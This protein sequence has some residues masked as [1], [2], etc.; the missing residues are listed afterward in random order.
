VFLPS[1]LHSFLQIYPVPSF[2][3]PVDCLGRKEGEGREGGRKE[4]RKE[5]RKAVKEGRKEGRKEGGEERR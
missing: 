2:L 3:S 5:G 1:F 4:G